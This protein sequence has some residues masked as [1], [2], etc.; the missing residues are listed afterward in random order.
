MQVP[1]HLPDLAGEEGQEVKI[2]IP[3]ARPGQIHLSARLQ[4]RAEQVRSNAYKTSI[5]LCL[6]HAFP[7]KSYIMFTYATPTHPSQPTYLNIPQHT[8]LQ[9]T[10]LKTPKVG[11]AGGKN[12][13][14][15]VTLF[16]YPFG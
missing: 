5:V 12:G 11:W 8:P 10:I 1:M 13:K 14:A 3:V 2:L 4:Y 9:V 7:R 16:S 6:F 15:E